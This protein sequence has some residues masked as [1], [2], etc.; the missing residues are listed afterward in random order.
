[1]YLV[2][3]LPPVVPGWPLPMK[4]TSSVGYRISDGVEAAQFMQALPKGIGTLWQNIW[5]NPVRMLV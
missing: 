3:P 1:V 5:K 4:A 2:F